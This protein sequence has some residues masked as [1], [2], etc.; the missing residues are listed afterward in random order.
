LV[1][2]ARF[3]TTD[4]TI[5]SRLHPRPGKYLG[6]MLEHSHTLTVKEA[7]KR[8]SVDPSTGLTEKQ[9]AE[10]FAQFGP[11]G[12]NNAQDLLMQRRTARGRGHPALEIDP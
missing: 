5:I 2:R 4:P 3:T 6:T 10:R 9:V 11:N 8:L 7:L 12:T 1:F